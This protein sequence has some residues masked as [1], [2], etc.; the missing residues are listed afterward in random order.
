M[1]LYVWQTP[2]PV[3]ARAVS[4]SAEKVLR[5]EVERKKKVFE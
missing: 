2:R 3:V 4:D 5:G 1:F